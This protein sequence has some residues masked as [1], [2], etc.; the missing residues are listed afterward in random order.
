MNSNRDGEFI[1]VIAFF[2]LMCLIGAGVME[3]ALR[4]NPELSLLWRWFWFLSPYWFLVALYPLSKLFGWVEKKAEIRKNVAWNKQRLQR[5]EEKATADADNEQKKIEACFR[6]AKGFRE[7]RLF[8]L[9][10]DEDATQA[11]R[12]AAINAYGYN[13]AAEI[14]FT[15]TWQTCQQLR[16]TVKSCYDWYTQSPV[17]QKPTMPQINDFIREK[18]YDAELATKLTNVMHQLLFE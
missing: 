4:F 2:G 13:D 3:V 10:D 14:F 12:V 8:W 6:A 9:G 18:V 1:F 16:A 5:L 7:P 17:G 11:L 15:A